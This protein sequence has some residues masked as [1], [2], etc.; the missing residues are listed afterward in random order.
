MLQAIIYYC[1]YIRVYVYITY[2]RTLQICVRTY[3]YMLFRP[4][5][6]HTDLLSSCRK[7]HLAIQQDKRTRAAATHMTYVHTYDRM[8]ECTCMFII[9]LYTSLSYSSYARYHY[10]IYTATKAL[11]ILHASFRPPRRLPFA[12]SAASSIT[13]AA[14]CPL[15]PMPVIVFKWFK[16]STFRTSTKTPARE[17]VSPRSAACA[18][19]PQSLST[20]IKRHGGSRSAAMPAS[21]RAWALWTGKA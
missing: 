10:I 15:R 19:R 7:T 20:F 16:P 17:S 11:I 6:A 8:I 12:H 3:T 14:R 5:T 13:T 4:C 18:C 2:I 1:T 21:P 9:A